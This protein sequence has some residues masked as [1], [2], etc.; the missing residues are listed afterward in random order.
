MNTTRENLQIFRVL[1][2]KEMKLFRRTFFSSIL[3]SLAL[4]LLNVLL[5]GY[6]FPLLGMPAHLILPLF[7]GNMVLII[8]EKTFA[9]AFGLIFDIRDKGLISYHSTLPLPKRWL[10]ASY[11]CKE[12]IKTAVLTIPL[13]FVGFLLLKPP[14]PIFFPPIALLM[15]ILML[16]FISTFFLMLSFW[17]DDRWFLINLWPRR[18]NPLICTGCLFFTWH[19]IASFSPIISKFLLLNPFTYITEGLRASLLTDGTY[20]SLP[21][22][23]SIVSISIVGA[24]WLLALGIKRRLDCV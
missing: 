23:I 10:F 22:C 3:D 1:L 14:S 12:M 21:L 8:V 4:L 15:Y 11:I 18:L 20:L 19:S 24:L 16:L 9:T 13:F 6:L 5:L 2:Q 7:L 17:Y